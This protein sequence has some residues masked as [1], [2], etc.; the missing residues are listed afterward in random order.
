MSPVVTSRARVAFVHGFAGDRASWDEVIARL[1]SIDAIRVAV[2]G[3]EAPAAASWDDGLA[4][5]AAQAIG[6]DAVVGY[7][8]GARIA[9]GLV[10]TGRARAAVLVSV[11]PGLADPSERAARAASDAAW[12]ARL[13]RDGIAAF[14]DAWEAQPLFATQARVA[15]AVLAARRARRLALDP[16]AL[17][18]SLETMGLAAMPDYRGSVAA[19]AGRLALVAGALDAKFADLA[20]GLVAESPSLPLDLIEESGHDPVLEQP[21]GLSRAIA[22]ALARLVTTV[23]LSSRSE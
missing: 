11:S 20:R 15:P 4:A 23:S 7:S 9:L 19:H 22:G 3:H 6:A 17:A 18:R 10:A 5:V 12:A 16:R 14:V 13:R 8:L 2:P 21:E 1:P